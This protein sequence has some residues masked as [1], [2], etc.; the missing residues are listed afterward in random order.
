[1]KAGFLEIEDWIDDMESK[2][3]GKGSVELAR[4]YVCL[5][6]RTRRQCSAG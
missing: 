2:Y 6:S 4:W 5:R 1:M 3:K